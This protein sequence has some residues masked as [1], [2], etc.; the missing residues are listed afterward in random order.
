MRLIYLH[1]SRFTGAGIHYHANGGKLDLHLDYGIHPISRMER[2]LNIILY[3][4]HDWKDEYGGHL[5]LWSYDE[6]GMN[7][8]LVEIMQ[9]T[10]SPLIFQCPSS[11]TLCFHAIGKP[12]ELS[13]TIF[14]AFNSAVLFQV[15]KEMTF[16]HE[17]RCV[18]TIFRLWYFW[19][20]DLWYIISWRTA[21]NMLSRRNW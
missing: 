13:K 7:V 11:T 16:V 8:L 10:S 18:W 2:R 3:L 20:I 4:N 15:R 19:I 1:F 9:S 12:K 5:E 14:P 17:R 6:K 21:P